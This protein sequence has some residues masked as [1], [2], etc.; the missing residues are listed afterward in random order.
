M[1]IQIK[2]HDTEWYIGPLQGKRLISKNNGDFMHMSGWSVELCDWRPTNQGP[3]ARYCDC[4]DV[5]RHL[6]NVGLTVFSALLGF[7][8]S[9]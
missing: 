9:H 4:V 2:I 3:M 8:A 7:F 5:R 6:K 1:D